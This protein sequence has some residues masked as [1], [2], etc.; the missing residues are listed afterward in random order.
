MTAMA[1]VAG[2]IAALWARERTGR[3]QHVTTS[4]LRTGLF[5]IGCDMNSALRIGRVP[6]PRT[7][8]DANNPLYNFYKTA[9]GRWL[10]LLGL[11]PERHLATIA[12]AIGMPELAED[13]RF[14]SFEALSTHH[15]ELFELLDRSFLSKTFEDCKRE[16]DDG[17]VWWT[18]VQSPMES[19]QD[20][21]IRAAGAFIEAPVTDGMVSAIAT[22]VDF[23]GTPW[24][25]RRRAPEAGEH[26]EEILLSL[27]HSWEE[28]GRL[29]ESG[30]F[31]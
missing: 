11:Q 22:P 27:G 16:L 9:D 29:Q 23:L 25:V 8:R 30:T 4:L 10:F 19:L 28:I 6:P 3:G 20:L 12:R 15:T 24:S 21:Q 17:G 18:P 13:T 14:S 26:T 1:G 5:M 31:G 7:R 2:T